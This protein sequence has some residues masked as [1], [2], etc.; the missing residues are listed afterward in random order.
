MLWRKIK[1]E[2]GNW[3]LLLYHVSKEVLTD[4]KTFEQRPK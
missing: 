2:A 1:L 4:D 3:D